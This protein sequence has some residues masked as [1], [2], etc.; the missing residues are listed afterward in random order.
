[1]IDFLAIG[2]HADDVEI[3]AGGTLAKLVRAGRVGGIVDLTDASMGTRG[4]SQERREEARRAAGILGASFREN[5]GLRDGFLVPH[6]QEAI[7]LLVHLFRRHRPRVVFTHPLRDRH[8]DHEACSSL[9]R[10]A[11]FKSGLAKFPTSGDPWRPHRV[12]HWM[13]ARDG[14]PQFC[15]EVSSTWSIRN[16]ALQAFATQFE[17]RP[18][19]PETPI[20]GAAFR[21]V[22]EARARH[23]GARIRGEYAEGFSC[24]EIPE[25]IDPCA[26][27]ER[28]F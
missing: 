3:S 15:V 23:L 19:F 18:G 12:F 20:S 4:T 13:G 16:E 9:V 1:M 24:E 26:L 17:E 11:A 22:V 7:L 25:I 10:E 28:E 8:P 2:A 27:S 5:L 21:D 14:E 6:D